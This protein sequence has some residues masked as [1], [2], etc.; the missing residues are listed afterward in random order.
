MAIGATGYAAA[1]RPCA[2]YSGAGALIGGLVGGVV[3]YAIYLG[4]AAAIVKGVRWVRG[5]RGSSWRSAALSPATISVL[6]L[7]AI[8][9]TMGRAL[10]RGRDCERTVSTSG[11]LTEKPQTAGLSPAQA[12]LITW[13]T[14]Y[15]PCF[16]FHGTVLSV[17]S[18]RLMAAERSIEAA[19]RS[20][21]VPR[22]SGTLD[23][24]TNAANASMAANRSAEMCFRALPTGGN[25]TLA[26]VNG[27]LASG[28]ALV[29]RGD[30]DLVR[31]LAALASGHQ[32]NDFKGAEALS[33]RGFARAKEGTRAGDALYV[34]LG[35]E[36]ALGSHLPAAEV[37]ALAALNRQK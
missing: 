34:Q 29:A 36:K 7:L 35:G 9:G 16:H 4:V 30:E 2:G 19:V 20:R 10:Q 11:R 3:I 15:F 31:G 8:F 22:I 6:F 17:Y 12:Q 14:A 37:E 24:A 18:R 25:A 13:L 28:Y 26:S 33:E 23:A 32:T 5:K 21:S 1:S 27:K